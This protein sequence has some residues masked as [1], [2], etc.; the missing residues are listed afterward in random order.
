MYN[1]NIIPYVIL[2]HVSYIFYLYVDTFVIRY[3]S[4]FI[5]SK[6]TH[7]GSTKLSSSFSC[8]C[9]RMRMLHINK[10]RKRTY[11]KELINMSIRI[12]PIISTN[13]RLINCNFVLSYGRPT[14]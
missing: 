5:S 13:S 1:V 7:Y 14:N 12:E 3:V 10:F 11:V 6:P 8:P 9:T 4:L 2:I